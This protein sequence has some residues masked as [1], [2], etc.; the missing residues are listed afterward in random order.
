MPVSQGTPLDPQQGSGSA[1]LVINERTRPTPNSIATNEGSVY[2]ASD[3]PAGV[4]HTNPEMLHHKALLATMVESIQ[5]EQG[6]NVAAD[7]QLIH[8]HLYHL[9]YVLDVESPLFTST[10]MCIL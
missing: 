2:T 9:A 7:A 6:P 8:T 5:H 4:G 3:T 1:T 10:I